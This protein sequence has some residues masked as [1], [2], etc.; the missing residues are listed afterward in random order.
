MTTFSELVKTIMIAKINKSKNR[1][2]GKIYSQDHLFVDNQKIE[3]AH[4]IEE[5][6]KGSSTEQKLNKYISDVDCKLD[7]LFFDLQ[8]EMGEE[9][10]TAKII[11]IIQNETYS[12]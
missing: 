9:E 11:E 12:I 3:I 5:I 2:N 6:G 4:L 10:A 1:W 8:D 7:D